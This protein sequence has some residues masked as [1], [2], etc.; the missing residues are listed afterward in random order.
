M[1]FTLT[2]FSFYVFHHFISCPSPVVYLICLKALF[3]SNTTEPTV[4]HPP[5][6]PPVKA[7]AFGTSS[8]QAVFDRVEQSLKKDRLTIESVV[9]IRRPHSAPSPQKSVTKSATQGNMRDMNFSTAR[10]EHRRQQEEQR[11]QKR[12][13]QQEAESLKC[14]LMHDRKRQMLIQRTLQN[15]EKQL[16]HNNKACQH[17][18]K[19]QIARAERSRKESTLQEEEERKESRRL[20]FLKAQRLWREEL[21]AEYNQR[22]QDQDKK[23]QDLLRSRMQSRK[24][25]FEREIQEQDMQQKKRED[26]KWTAFQNRERFQQK[27]EKECQQHHNLQQY[28]REQNLLRLRASM[29]S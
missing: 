1:H 16:E 7:H 3:Q 5:R 17:M 9:H 29:L 13:Q 18:A 25:A 11:Q 27:M 15:L 21:Q 19:L 22:N 2:Y 8:L 10:V 23:R 26:A 4:Q 24:E 12:E 14:Q 6:I 20:Q 28:L